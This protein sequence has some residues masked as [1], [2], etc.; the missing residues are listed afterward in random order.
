M[1]DNEVIH[2][3]ATSAMG[4][5]L[6]TSAPWRPG[7]RTE[8]M[9]LPAGV[10]TICAGYRGGSIELTVECDEATADAVQASLDAWRQE[11]P[12]QTPFGCVE[13]REAEASVFITADC[14]FSWK[15]DGVY[16][17]AEPTTLGAQN[18]N[19]RIHRS[20]SPS[21]TT[22]ADYSQATERN[23]VLVFPEFVRGSRTNPARITGVA[24]VVGTL[25]NKPAFFSM[26]PV[27]AREAGKRRLTADDVYEHH[28]RLQN[29]LN[30][31]YERHLAK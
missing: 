17:T 14:G 5:K 28:R 27:R 30:V 13:H 25:T 23:G 7:A 3:R 29:A 8:F 15:G 22:D 31:I 21:F 10:S 19:G 6:G 2:C 12:K 9:F 18:V 24:F 16:L 20:W 26:S 1:R 11:R 4:P